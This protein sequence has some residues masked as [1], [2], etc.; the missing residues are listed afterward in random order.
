MGRAPQDIP[1][2]LDIAP[3]PKGTDTAV[4]CYGDNRCDGKDNDVAYLKLRFI[5][6]G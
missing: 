4:H 6:N 3:K 5:S 1:C 2:P